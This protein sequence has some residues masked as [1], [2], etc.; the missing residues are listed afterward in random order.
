METDTIQFD[1]YTFLRDTF[2]IVATLS[3]AVWG[4]F[5]YRRQK[6]EERATAIRE[7]LIKYDNNCNVLNHL[8]TFDV[9]HEMVSCVI[10]SP[11]MHRN[12]QRMHHMLADEGMNLREIDPYTFSWPWPITIPLHSQLI[13]DYEATI[14]KNQEI[15]ATLGTQLP[16]LYK[17]FLCVHNLFWSVLANTKGFVRDE[18]ILGQMW[19]DTKPFICNNIEIQKDELFNIMI[20][21]VLQGYDVEQKNIDDAISILKLVTQSFLKLNNKQLEKQRKLEQKMTWGKYGSKSSIFEEFQETE[22]A[23]EKIMSHEELLKFR[24]LYTK[25]QVRKEE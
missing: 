25:I 6:N 3:A 20:G 19:L 2:L 21:A 1:W 10:Y 4:Y 18:Q 12:L 17:V 8:L 11:I 14:R 23:L 13:D 22:K 7:L 16:S 9:V 15:C 5:S 24:E